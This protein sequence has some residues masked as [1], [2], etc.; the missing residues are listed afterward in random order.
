MRRNFNR[1]I[2]ED[3]YTPEG[4]PAS[5]ASEVSGSTRHSLLSR[6]AQAE[7]RKRNTIT[8]APTGDAERRFFDYRRLS[9]K[10]TETDFQHIRSNIVPESVKSKHGMFLNLLAQ[11]Q[12]FEVLTLDLSIKNLTSTLQPFQ[13]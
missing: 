12:Q 11:T 9:K 6:D 10:I 4:P 8:S 5:S 13:S 7:E 3:S 1:D 2:L